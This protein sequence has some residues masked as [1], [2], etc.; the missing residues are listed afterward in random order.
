MSGFVVCPACG[1]RI[2]AGRQHCLRCFAPL[3]DPEAPIRPPVGESLGLSQGQL[4]IVGIGASLLVLS[5]VAVIWS[6][7][8]EPPDDEA[9]PAAA[10]P[11]RPAAPVAPASATA[12]P[13]ASAAPG[14]SEPA[15][16][17][18]P[19]GIAEIKSTEINPADRAAL[20]AS[21][22]TYEE[23]LAKTPD[24]PET[25]NSLGRVLGRLNRPDEAIARFERAIALAPAVA[26]YH[27]NLAHLAA[28]VGQRNR[29]V[30]EYREVARLLPQDYATRYT[31]AL[32][33]QKN[34]DN[35]AALSEF[36][37]AIALAPADAS[38]HLAYAVSLE[39]LQRV[40]DAVRE[41]RRYLEM[42]PAAPDAETIKAHIEALRSGQP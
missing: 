30:E 21:R 25:L 33:L 29:A 35:E 6:T 28:D 14:G 16:A 10:Q 26:T 27:L 15:P 13:S 5:L 23:A 36:E 24:D 42:R 40:P 7:W 17:A 1:T 3:P 32:A 18:E 22:A 8:P 31:L 12:A 19:A 38:L 34:G 9:R 4:M 37:R 2:K 20:E 39:Q 11:V 41:Y